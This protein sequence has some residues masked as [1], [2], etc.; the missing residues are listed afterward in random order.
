MAHFGQLSYDEQ[1]ALL[2]EA[3]ALWHSAMGERPLYFRPGTFSANDSTFRALAELGFRG[4]SI[5]APGR[6]YPEIRA[7]WTGTEPD[8]HRTNA[9]FRL[10]PGNMML[11]NM[12]LSADF[13]VLLDMRSG[14]RAHA[15]FRPDV[16]WPGRFSIGYRTIAENILR[17]VTE[18][19]PAI[20]VLNSISHNHYDYGNRADPACMR[21]LTMLDELSGA[22][23]RAGVR[24]VG[25]TVRDIVE[26]TLEIEPVPEEFLYI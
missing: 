6:V 14:R 1:I 22:C 12:P 10:L 5:S 2:S 4:G 21:Y 17:Q 3:A 19:R 18:R 26:K 8:P 23:M 24:T 7:V 15:D 20:P 9:S 25:H 16:D 13:S 11:G